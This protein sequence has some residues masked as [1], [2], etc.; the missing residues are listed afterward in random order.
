MYP[1]STVSDCQVQMVAHRKQ[2]PV[3]PTL[4][5]SINDK[6]RKRRSSRATG[7][8]ANKDSGGATLMFRT[9]PD[10]HHVSLQDWARFI[11]GKKTPMSPESPASPSF[12][13]P[14]APR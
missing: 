9:L 2:G 7:L 4:V 14:F 6:E 1:L 11:I 13:N 10:D 3:L 8:V 12:I 5:I